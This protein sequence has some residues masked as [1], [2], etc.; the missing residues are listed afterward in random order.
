MILLILASSILPSDHVGR[1]VEP[2]PAL[3]EATELYA[4]CEECYDELDIERDFELLEGY[5][6]WLNQ[7]A[8]PNLQ[9][10]RGSR[11][12]WQKGVASFFG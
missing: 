7:D 6:P 1:P 10:L 5:H 3:Q 11:T 8:S 4:K 9:H 2:A 12:R